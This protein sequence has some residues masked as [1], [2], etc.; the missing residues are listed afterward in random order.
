MNYSIEDLRLY[1]LNVGFSRH[2][3]DWNWK[4]VHSPF[5]RLYYVT[6]GE[7]MVVMPSGRYYLTPGH[8]YLI[9]PFTTH[10]YICESMFEHYYAHI[11]EDSQ[12]E[13]CFLEDFTFPFELEASSIELEL[14]Q[15]LHTRNLFLELPESNPISYD[16]QV[17]LVNN[18][19][20]NHSRPFYD[21]V[22]SRGILY[23]L[24]SGFMKNA[25]PKEDIK[26]DRISLILKHIRKNYNQDID[27]SS[28]AD[29]ACMSKGHFMRMFKQMT[30]ESPNA[31]ILRYKTERAEQMLATTNLPVKNI[32]MT[33]GYDDFSYFIRIFKK[34]TGLTPQQYRERL[35]YQ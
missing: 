35:V 14:F 24:F 20:K 12:K 5:A 17:S 26:D 31:Y 29:L 4:N 19:K 21:K 13:Y 30:G 2:Y 18:L 27:I 11:Y 23:Y 16:N 33:L 25:K 7:A 15:K 28:L 34:K 3:C 8:L 10:S 6:A 22:H 1:L 9:P 32:A